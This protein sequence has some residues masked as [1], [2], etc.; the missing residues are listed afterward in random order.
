MICTIY[1]HETG[2]ETLVEEL[3]AKFPTGKFSFDNQDEFQIVKVDLKG[4]FFSSSKSIKV[5]YRMRKIPGYTLQ[6]FECPLVANLLGMA[7]LIHSMEVELPEVKS[8]LLRKIATL[9]SEFSVFSEPKLTPEAHD[10]IKSIS[11][12]WDAI[13]FAQPGTEISQSEVQHFLDKN[14]SL[15]LDVNGSAALSALEVKINSKHHDAD[16]SKVTEDQASR[17]SHNET[18]L[19]SLGIRVNKNLPCIESEAETT[20]RSTKEIAE[21]AVALA[22]TNLVAFNGMTG[23]QAL[24][25]LQKY[26]LLNLATPNEID[27]LQNPTD[28]RKNAETWKCEGIWTLLWALG[29]IPDLGSAADMCNLNNIEPSKYPIVRDQNPSEFIN[30]SFQP[31][32]KKE[33]LDMADLYYRIDWAC[34]NARL[35]GEEMMEANPGVVYERHFA[36][37]W[38]IGYQGVEW[39]EISCDT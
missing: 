22:I 2:F 31:K 16:Q 29:I 38:L 18:L 15:I 9:N 35:K 1:S 19:Q 6:G 39:D 5:A 37:N 4:G 17:K 33:I 28:E 13:S 11:K 20:H 3:K 32:S 14:L 27:F 23:E 21:R 30:K 8:L 36:L 12:K 34:V 26:N 10:F 24:E 7:G 25:Y